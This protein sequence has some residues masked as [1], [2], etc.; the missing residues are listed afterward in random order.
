MRYCTWVE[1][2]GLRTCDES[3]WV[4]FLK[5]STPLPRCIRL[6]FPFSCPLPFPHLTS[7]SHPRSRSLL[8]PTRALL[9]TLSSGFLIG[10]IYIWQ[11]GADLVRFFQGDYVV[12]LGS[13]LP[14][15][16]LLLTT[17]SDSQRLL[18]IPAQSN[19]RC[20]RLPMSSVYSK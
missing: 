1:Y 13:V 12:G 6:S 17:P 7:H 19:T 15:L 10:V 4:N 16:P 20:L 9:S 18:S 8:Y 3:Y 5:R 11:C 2:V 14:S